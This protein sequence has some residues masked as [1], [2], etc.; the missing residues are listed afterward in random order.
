MRLLLCLDQEIEIFI[1]SDVF[2]IEEGLV[3]CFSK[4]EST[5]MGSIVV[6]FPE[7]V[8]DVGLDVVKGGIEFFAEE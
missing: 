5:G 8:V 2:G 3:R 7:P 4:T 1:K 6:V